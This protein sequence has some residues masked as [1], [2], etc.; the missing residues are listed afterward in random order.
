[1]LQFT[2]LSSSWYFWKLYQCLRKHKQLERK[3]DWGRERDK[4]WQHKLSS[5][6]DCQNVSWET[7]YVQTQLASR[8]VYE[9]TEWTRHSLRLIR[10]SGKEKEW[11]LPW[12]NLFAN[13]DTLWETH[14]LG[15]RHLGPI[16]SCPAHFHCHVGSLYPAPTCLLLCG[17]ALTACMVIKKF[18]MSNCNCP[19]A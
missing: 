11:G 13:S 12:R 5:T 14:M 1:M 10:R 3:T 9:T 18:C 19:T 4:S 17:T 8:M 16:L 15:H 6:V 7:M 2:P